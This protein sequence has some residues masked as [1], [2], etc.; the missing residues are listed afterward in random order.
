MNKEQTAKKK[1]SIIPFFMYSRYENFKKKYRF[2]RFER[3]KRANKPTNFTECNKKSDL[4]EKKLNHTAEKIT[5]PRAHYFSKDN[6]F[7]RKCVRNSR[8]ERNHINHQYIQL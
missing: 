3:I 1:K 7:R 5:R 4:Y 8:A 6:L 2:G